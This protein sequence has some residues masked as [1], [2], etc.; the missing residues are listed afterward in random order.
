[1]ATQ[2]SSTLGINNKVAAAAAAFTPGDWYADAPPV[3]A[4]TPF[5]RALNLDAGAPI[6]TPIVGV[7]V[8]VLV[9]L[10]LERRR[11][12]LGGRK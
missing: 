4:Q 3:A 9:L 7:V 12:H 6:H 8:V 5:T 1:M 2:A 11:L 10:F